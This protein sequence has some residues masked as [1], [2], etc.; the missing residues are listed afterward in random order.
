MPS[1]EGASL[2][3]SGDGMDAKSG[4]G[5]IAATIADALAHRT[6]DDLA[7]HIPW[8]GYRRASLLTEGELSLVKKLDAIL[9]SESG[10]AR[11][12]KSGSKKGSSKAEGSSET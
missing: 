12:R 2:T 9:R 8:D 11:P 7:R 10:K 6:A 5:S 1:G 4:S 3:D